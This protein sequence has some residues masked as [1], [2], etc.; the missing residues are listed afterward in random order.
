MQEMEEMHVRYLGWEDAL[1]EGMTTLSSI[2]AWRIPQ[3]EKPDGLQSKGLQ[4]VGCDR[5]NLAYTHAS[6]LSKHWFFHHFF[7]FAV[8]SVYFHIL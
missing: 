3:T 1:E 7:S 5:N 4:R 2:L 8:Y 6:S